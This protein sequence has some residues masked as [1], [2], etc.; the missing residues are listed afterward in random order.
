VQRQRL[1]EA[2]EAG[3]I[4]R[5]VGKRVGSGKILD[6]GFGEAGRRVVDT[7]RAFEAKLR[8]SVGEPGGCDMISLDI[9]RPGKLAWLGRD[10]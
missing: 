5:A 1:D 9:P 6:I 10:F 2:R 3:A 4:F 7:Y 8:G